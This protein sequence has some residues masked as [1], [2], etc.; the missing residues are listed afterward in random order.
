VSE[1]LGIDES[2]QRA[3][4]VR[5][6]V[7][8]KGLDCFA[9]LGDAYRVL[10]NFRPQFGEPQIAGRSFDQ[11]HAKL[12]LELRCPATDSGDGH[13][14]PARRLGEASGRNHFREHRQR[15]RSAIDSSNLNAKS[16]RTGAGI[17]P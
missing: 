6:P 13:L 7:R 16:R 15:M 14:E 1:T 12:I 9:E 17:G 5:H 10:Q 3:R 8:N 4:D 2:P 11:A